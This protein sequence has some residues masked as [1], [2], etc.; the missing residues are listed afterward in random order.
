MFLLWILNIFHIIFSV[1]IDDFEQV[2]VISD[3]NCTYQSYVLYTDWVETDNVNNS[4]NSK[5]RLVGEL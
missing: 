3:D 5:Y 4:N 2:N 1:S